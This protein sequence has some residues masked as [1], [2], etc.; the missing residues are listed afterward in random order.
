MGEALVDVVIGANGTPGEVP[1]GSCANVALALGRLGRELT[2]ITR[3]GNDERGADVRR[4]LEDSDA[5]VRGS[6]A[7]RTAIAEA[8]LDMNGSASYR[9]ELDWDLPE[10][11]IPS[12][13]GLVHFG[14]IGVPRT[15][16]GCR[17]SGHRTTPRICDRL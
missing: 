9:V 6:T 13:A 10:A 3:L 1:G 17:R 2:L 5:T 8:N 16:F 14:S 15:R 4:S 11:S 12:S 7:R